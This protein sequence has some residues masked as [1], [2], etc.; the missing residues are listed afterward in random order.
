MASELPEVHY[1]RAGEVDI[2]YQVVGA[3]PVDLVIVPPIVSHLE[4]EWELGSYAGFLDRLSSFCR[5]VRFDKRGMGLS[6]RIEGAPTL[7]ERMDDLRAVLDDLGLR[8][9]HLLGISEG[10]ALALLFA[11]THPERVE[12]VSTFCGFARLTAAPDFPEAHPV[13]FFREFIAQVEKDWG[14]GRA[15]AGRGTRNCR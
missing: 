10:G 9:A 8:R 2:A 13:E 12:S 3:G 11:A 14:H 6:D 5:L 15:P 1:V 7:E 4:I